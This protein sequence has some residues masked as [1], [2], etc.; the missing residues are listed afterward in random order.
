MAGTFTQ[1]REATE[2]TVLDDGRRVNIAKGARVHIL[3]AALSSVDEFSTS[4]S[5]ESYTF[6]G[7]GPHACLGR[8]VCEIA[9]TELFRAVFN[10]EGL[11]RV[12]GPLGSLKKVPGTDG[13]ELYLSEDW[14][15][16]RPFPASMK[17]TF[18]K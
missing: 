2:D 3:S 6:L 7:A 13:A 17:V 16:T 11:G 14:G 5:A 18:A 9:L 4:R 12:T 10:K 1:M 8:E 15:H